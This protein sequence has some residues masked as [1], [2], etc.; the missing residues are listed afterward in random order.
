MKKILRLL[1]I[2]ILLLAG[3]LYWL[4][5]TSATRFDE[6]SKYVHVYEQNTAE[7]EMME[8]LSGSSLVNNT[9]LF[10]FVASRLNVWKRIK[11]GRFEITKGQSLMSIVRMLRNNK[12]VPSKLVINKLRV[13]EDL[14]KLIGRNFRTD[15]ATAMQ[16]LT[17]KDSLQKLGVDS[18]SW[19][20]LVIPDTYI[21]NWNT[22]TFKILS[23]LKSEQEDFWTAERK[24]KAINLGLTPEQVYALASIVEEETNANQEKGN[25]AS[26]YMNR[27]SKGMALGADPTIK[28]ALKNFALRRIHFGDLQVASPYNTYRNKGL[29]P[30]PICTPS[31][32]TIDAVLDAPRTDYLFFVA[33]AELNGTH[34]FSSTYAEHQQYAKTYQEELNKRGINK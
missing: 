13:P 11:P 27:I 9:G 12:Q 18:D 14:A 2:V 20:T 34:H 7:S 6:K 3:V 10:R 23:R 33:S 28:F 17:N 29:P 1:F 21:M 8:Q 24:Q 32:I 22:S 5:F 4:L 25:I 26:V 19:L 16:F 31:K 30:G 15:S